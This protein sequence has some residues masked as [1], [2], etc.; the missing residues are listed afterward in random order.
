MNFMSM[1]GKASLFLDWE[2]TPTDKSEDIK[3]F[4]TI[5][6]QDDCYLTFKQRLP[7]EKA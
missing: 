1:L 3:V 7:L 4:A 2:H 6:P 5:F